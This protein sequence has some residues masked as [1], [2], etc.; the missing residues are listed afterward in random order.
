MKKTLLGLGVSF[1][2]FF[3]LVGVAEAQGVSA[4]QSAQTGITTIGSLITLLTTNVVK[5]LG[6]LALASGVVAFFYGIVQYIWGLRAGD[7]GK[8]KVGN[9]FMGWGLLGLFVMFSVY[10]IIKYAQDI[11]GIRDVSTI[12]IPDI[13]FGR[14]TTGGTPNSNATGGSPLGGTP[15][16]GATG[17]AS[18][19][20]GASTGGAPGS[21]GATLIQETNG[22]RY[23]SDGT[24]I[25]PDGTYYYQGQ[26]VTGPGGQGSPTGNQ[27][28]TQGGSTANTTCRS[29]AQPC[30]FGGSSGV[31]Q[32]NPETGDLY[33]N[34]NVFTP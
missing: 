7:A 10:G 1:T 4:S 21:N 25:G 29:D 28:P 33:C 9:A 14:N 31:C 26:A 22:W 24:A 27:T 19:G 18:T 15:N 6:T 11:F 13:N 16:A 2:A 23:Y 5:A 34:V 12:T 17:G 3:I 8:T 30:T 32:P 20:A